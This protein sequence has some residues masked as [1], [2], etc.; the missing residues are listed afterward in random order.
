MTKILV[1][2][3]VGIHSSQAA[4]ARKCRWERCDTDRGRQAVGGVA[5]WPASRCLT[6]T[7]RRCHPASGPVERWR[8]MSVGQHRFLAG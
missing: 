3:Q 2:N 6:F 1:Y 7:A 4:A 5:A 8:G